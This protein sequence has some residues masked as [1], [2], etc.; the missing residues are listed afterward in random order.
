MSLKGSS[1]RPSASDT[2]ASSI[3]VRCEGPFAAGVTAWQKRAG[4]TVFTVVVKAT[5]AL[6]SELCPLLDESEALQEEDGFWD[7]DADRSLYAPSDMALM[8][9]SAEVIVLGHA[10]AAEQRPSH[11]ITARIAVGSIDKV[12]EAHSQRRFERDGRCETSPA[13]A[14]LPLHYEAAS[15]GP[16]SDNPVGI[17]PTDFGENG[18]RRVP[19]V[20]PPNLDVRPGEHIA[21]VGLGPIAAHWPPRARLLRP[22]DVAWLRAPLERP[23]PQG[24]DARYFCVAPPDQR[25]VEPFRVDERLILEGLSAH[26]ARLVTNLA[27]VAPCVSVVGL[28]NRPGPKLIADL[29][30]IDTDRGIAT[31][32][33][34]GHLSFDGPVPAF[35]LL[36][37]TVGDREETGTHRPRG[38]MIADPPTSELPRLE[39]PKAGT[40]SLETTHVEMTSSSD[41]SAALPFAS[42]K[43]GMR[44]RSASQPDDALPFRSPTPPELAAPPLAQPAS[45]DSSV[46]QRSAPPIPPPPLSVRASALPPFPPPT[47]STGGGLV[48]AAPPTVLPLAP[49]PSVAPAGVPPVGAGLIAPSPSSGSVR[50]P[51]LASPPVVPP[52]LLVP[53]A[54]ISSSGLTPSTMP[55]LRP[56]GQSALPPPMGASLGA[57]PP[58]SPMVV[59]PARPSTL[60]ERLGSATPAAASDASRVVSRRESP[61]PPRA[62]ESGTTTAPDPLRARD[63][64]QVAFSRSPQHNASAASDDRP[65]SMGFDS[66]KAAS[67]AALVQADRAQ[68]DVGA[69]DRNR[70]E[71]EPLSVKRR[72]LVDLLSFEPALPRRLRRS[73]AYSEVLADFNPPRIPRRPDE[74][75]VERDREERGRLDVLRVLSCGIPLDANELMSAI[76]RSLDDPNDLELP[77]F[78][79]AGELRPTLDEVEALRA[80]VAVAQPLGGNDKRLAAAVAIAVDALAAPSPP[81][82]Q[83]AVALHRQIETALGQLSLPPRYLAEQV[84]HSLLTNR[85]YRKPTILGANRIRAE[86]SSSSGATYPAY[87][88]DELCLRLPMLTSFPVVALVELHPREDAS[89]Q[90]ADALLVSA[91]GRIVRTARNPR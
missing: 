75:D 54:P 26:H 65:R 11:A 77:L 32:T 91:L 62:S 6:E 67:D 78:L 66:A 15:G 5:Y 29:L 70:E 89:E 37:S 14:R 25:A 39:L 48:A 31:L 51:L 16:G 24:F 61:P 36:V 56:A 80:A 83:T 69:K 81:L 87:L 44:S 73:R 10:Y 42:T 60:G 21:I 79:V 59:P 35:S 72:A 76:E 38:P 13:L 18:R 47:A 52:S 58:M 1:V 84:E 57:L 63:P 27:G 53:P 88:P 20:L 50:P 22:Q 85:R 90:S 9:P 68:R 4:E 34:R 40:D 86:L 74:S 19:G 8:K 55:G 7:D 23:M 45:E 64:F 49:P 71:P 41:R 3:R 30:R 43:G 2:R 46:R 12:I 33:F 82:R 17:D 28:A